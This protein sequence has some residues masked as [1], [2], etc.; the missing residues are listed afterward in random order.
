MEL[1]YFLVQPVD[2]HIISTYCRKLGNFSVNHWCVY[3]LNFVVQV[4]VQYKP[5]WNKGFRCVQISLFKAPMKI[6]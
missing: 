5:I 1:L 2:L 6:N 3:C 4:L